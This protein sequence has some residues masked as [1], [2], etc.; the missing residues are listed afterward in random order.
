MGVKMMEQFILSMEET[1]WQAVANPCF[2]GYIGI[3]QVKRH[4]ED[5]VDHRRSMGHITMV[6]T[7][8]QFIF[9]ENRAF[10]WEKWPF[11]Y[12]FEIVLGQ[13]M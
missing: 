5:I 9:L 3:Q 7:R 8:M 10:I 6:C 12:W 4:A 11:S 13:M 1:E 2:E